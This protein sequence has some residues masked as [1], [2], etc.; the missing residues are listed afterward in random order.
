MNS[1]R[2]SSIAERNALRSCI[3]YCRDGDT[4]IVTKLD[5]LARSVA[6][7]EHGLIVRKLET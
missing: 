2:F 3:D 5:R 7:L 1:C 6:A 4:L